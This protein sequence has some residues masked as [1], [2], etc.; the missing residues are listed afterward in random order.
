M[1]INEKDYNKLNSIQ[2]DIKVNVN[3][4]TNIRKGDNS[5]PVL[6]GENVKKQPQVCSKIFFCLKINKFVEQWF[7]FPYFMDKTC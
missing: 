7:M 2:D 4:M 6:G 5:S 1:E 3:S